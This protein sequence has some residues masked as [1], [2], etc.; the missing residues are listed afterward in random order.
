MPIQ[1]AERRR[2]SIASILEFAISITVIA[3]AVP[4]S[5]EVASASVDTLF[6]VE[7][8]PEVIFSLHALPNDG[9]LILT[10]HRPRHAVRTRRELRGHTEKRD[11][12]CCWR[13]GNDPT[14]A[15]SSE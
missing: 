9:G 1:C 12:Q 13:R 2:L 11:E 8:L 3:A 4:R 7:E 5:H 14:R 15:A 10:T 6:Y